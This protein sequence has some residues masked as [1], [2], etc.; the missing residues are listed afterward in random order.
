MASENCAVVLFDSGEDETQGKRDFTAISVGDTTGSR[1][2]GEVA[3]DT[4]DGADVRREGRCVDGGG[5]MV[6]SIVGDGG[7][8]GRWRVNGQGGDVGRGVWRDVVVGW[9][10]SCGGGVAA[11]VD[12][13]TGRRCWAQADAAGAETVAGGV[14]KETCKA[15]ATTECAT[16]RGETAVGDAGATAD[17]GDRAWL[18]LGP[19]QRRTRQR[20]RLRVWRRQLTE[21]GLRLR[22]RVEA[23]AAP[24]DTTTTEGA[25]EATAAGVDVVTGV[26]EA[27]T[28]AGGVETLKGDTT[29][30]GVGGAGARGVGDMG[31]IMGDAGRAGTAGATG[32]GVGNV[33]VMICRRSSMRQGSGRR[34]IIL[35]LPGWSPSQNSSSQ[36]S[37]D[38]LCA[39]I[40]VVWSR[41]D[42]GSEREMKGGATDGAGEM[43]GGME[44]ARCVGACNAGK[45]GEG[46][47]NGGGRWAMR[48]GRDSDRTGCE[49]WKP[50]LR[51]EGTELD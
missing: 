6:V 11:S 26:G 51:V 33:K 2:A 48:A 9:G 38:R 23:V 30:D 34:E 45:E 4:A 22:V 32:A 20:T 36:S 44:R 42:G 19:E 24:G 47:R 35:R 7:T 8:R 17:G 25:G 5:G 43:I 28:A 18:G 37:W 46:S 15:G 40:V 12:R 14:T 10:F 1:A 21:P 16:D 27:E 13:S 39:L 41:H 29:I 50:G 49:G 31:A 3:D